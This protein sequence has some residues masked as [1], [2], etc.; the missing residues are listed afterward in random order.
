MDCTTG[1]QPITMII[2]E[3]S[4]MKRYLSV[5][6]LLKQGYHVTP[7]CE[8]YLNITTPACTRTAMET[9]YILPCFQGLRVPITVIFN[10]SH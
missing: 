7:F 3:S 1:Q 2:I 10:T 8:V 6:L 5:W 9:K 4:L